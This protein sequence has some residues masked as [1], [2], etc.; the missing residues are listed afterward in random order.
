M[1]VQT[2]KEFPLL[3]LMEQLESMNCVR[4]SCEV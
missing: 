4:Y 2:G 3:H 1:T